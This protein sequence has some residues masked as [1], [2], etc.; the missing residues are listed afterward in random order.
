MAEGTWHSDTKCST[1]GL[2]LL[3]RQSPL[4]TRVVRAHAIK[5]CLTLVDAISRTVGAD[6]GAGPRERLEHARR[7]ILRARA[8]ITSELSAAPEPAPQAPP[9]FCAAEQVVSAAVG[10]V[11]ERAEAGQVELCVQCGVGGVHGDEEALTLALENIV[12]NAIEATAAFGSVFVT[13]HELMP[14]DQCWTVEDTGCGIPSD[15]LGR[16]GTSRGP[17]TGGLAIA[18]E[19]VEAH[20]GLVH[21][22]SA[23]CVGTVVTI[24]LPTSE[25]AGATERTE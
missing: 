24:W 15:L 17:R 6:L 8:L 19:I 11:N 10:R 3:A 18:R 1:S 12:L 25:A 13:T 9:A 5:N 16:M 4:S 14:G 20:G 7:A 21:I 2:T 23:P 22:E